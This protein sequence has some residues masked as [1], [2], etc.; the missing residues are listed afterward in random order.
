MKKSVFKTAVAIG[1]AAFLISCNTTRDVAEVT[2][3]L[4]DSIQSQRVPD[5]RVALFTIK[6]VQQGDTMLLTGKT[7]DKE[8]LNELF[9]VLEKQDITFT[10]SIMR[11]PDSKLGDHTWGLINLSV[12]NI[13]YSPSQSAEMATQALMGTPVKILQ[14]DNAYF[15]IQTPDNYISWTESAG[16]APISESRLQAWKSTERVIFTGDFGL[17]YSQPQKDSDPVSDLVSGGILEVDGN[18]ESSRGFIPVILPDGRNGFIESSQCADFQ[19]WLDDRKEDPESL[20]RLA[21]SFA[22]RPYLWGGTSA[23]AFD[24]SGF[25]KTIYFM[26][27]WILSRDA[28]QQVNQGTEIDRTDLL[29]SVQPGDLLFFGRKATD[30]KPERATHVGMYTGNSFFIH[31]SGLVRINSLDS[32]RPEYKKYYTENLLHVKRILGSASQPVTIRNHPWYN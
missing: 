30:E 9:Q 5:S 4:I 12:A 21:K 14:E 15:L 3:F 25:T 22:G 29:A 32:T 2:R 19:S 17:I 28:S 16:I 8:A 11:L 20:I 7:T 10:D 31:C 27:G 18:E 24:C 6:A 26:H 23:K 1:I 13:R